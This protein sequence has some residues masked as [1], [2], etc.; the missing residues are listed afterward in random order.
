VRVL[1]FHLTTPSS[2][3]AN[4][5]ANLLKHLPEDIDV[6]LVLN[7]RALDGR[8]SSLPPSVAMRRVTVAPVDVGLPLDPQIP[9]PLHLRLVTRVQHLMRREEVV[10]V[11]ENY[12]PEIVYTSQ[13]RFDCY[14]GEL[15]ARRLGVPQVVHLH[16]NP[17]PWL[18]Y[19]AMQRIKSCDRVIAVSRFIGRLA[20]K[21][22]VPPSRVAVL[23]NTIEMRDPR[24]ASEKD[25]ITVG[26]IGRL[27]PGK[28]FDDSVRAFARL[29]EQ[30]PSA[31][32]VL[33]GDGSERT[34]VAKLVTSLRLDDAI[35]F[36]GWQSNV[37]EWLA[38]LDIFINPS[39]DEPFGLAVLEASAAGIPVVAYDEGGVAEIIVNGETGLLA[40]PGDVLALGDALVR[41]ATDAK[42][43][44]TL[45]AA[46]RSRAATVFTPA[47]A[48]HSFAEILRSVTSSAR[49]SAV[50]N[51]R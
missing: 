37:D 26:Q 15:A 10:R 44:A 17:G 13:Q 49:Q 14:V 47:V 31:R 35:Q 27:A 29:R 7:Q 38:R 19:R 30:L 22:G 12:R 41:L 32:L 28:G 11:A 36:T 20:E 50:G 34:R 4:V 9:R 45:G 21:H 43:R 16:Y 33:V 48:A 46:A 8:R 25:V 23:P 51:G 5:L 39:R 18:R 2:S 6:K 42:L 24:V 40:P 3:E 1:A